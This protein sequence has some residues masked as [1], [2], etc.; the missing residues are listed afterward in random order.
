MFG[1]CNTKLYSNNRDHSS[2]EI[3]SY[4]RKWLVYAGGDGDL[5]KLTLRVWMGSDPLLHTFLH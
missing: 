3:R 1:M 5:T 2:R 4:I